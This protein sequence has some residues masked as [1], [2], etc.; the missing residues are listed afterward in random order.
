VIKEAM[1]VDIDH[2][3]ELVRLAEEVR[4]TNV[5]RVLR[6]RN[7]ALAV[8]TPI[9]SKPRARR[10]V[11]TKADDDAFLASAGGWSDADVDGFLE[12]NA[13]SRRLAP[14]PPVEL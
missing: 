1:P 5:P 13:T 11:V 14:Q 7:E 3:P 6:R 4:A 2:V 8:L 10:R 12:E 9:R